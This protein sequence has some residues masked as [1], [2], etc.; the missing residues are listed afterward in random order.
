MFLV[1]MKKYSFNII[2]IYINIFFSTIDISI[3]N[4]TSIFTTPKRTF[5]QLRSKKSLRLPQRIHNQTHLIGG[6]GVRL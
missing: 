2:F 4:I 5:C 1:N 3:S 6:E